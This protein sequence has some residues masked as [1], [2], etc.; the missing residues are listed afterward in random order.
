MKK[1]ITLVLVLVMLFSLAACGDNSGSGNAD[2]NNGGAS[3]TDEN[4]SGNAGDLPPV[5]ETTVLGTFPLPS[6]FTK[7]TLYPKLL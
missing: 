7:T 3:Q 4:K 1:I 6:T 5:G 2:N